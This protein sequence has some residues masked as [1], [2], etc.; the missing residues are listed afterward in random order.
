M[1]KKQHII[2][3]PDV[4][5]IGVYAIRNKANNKYYIGSSSNIKC[6]MKT[7]RSNLEKL[8]GSNTKMDEDLKSK[9]DIKNF[10][11]LVLEVFDDYKITETELREREAFYIKKYNAYDG[12]NVSGRT[13]FTNGYF[14]K[15]EL[16]TSRRFYYNKKIK[17]EDVVKMSHVALI[18]KYSKLLTS[19]EQRETEIAIMKQEILKRMGN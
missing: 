9:D 18:Q 8:Y 6:R 10:E 11:F 1:N 2:Q 15:N 17:H 12:Y 16:L 19:G 7:H 14:Q 13:P 3:V 5:K 4:S